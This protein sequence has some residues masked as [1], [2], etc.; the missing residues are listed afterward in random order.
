MDQLEISGLQVHT[1]IGIH[2]WEQKIKQKLLID[3]TI[4]TEFSAGNDQLEN[5]IDYD[6]LSRQV[7]NFVESQPFQLIETVAER[8][9]DLIKAGFKV[10]ELTVSVSKPG[11]I[12][13]A[14]NVKVSVHR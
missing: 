9:A 12:P 13:Q 3:I 5:V 10:P 14:S 4:A 6:S 11:A 1:Q 2:Q 7:I 8:V